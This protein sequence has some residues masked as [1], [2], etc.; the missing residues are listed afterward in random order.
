NT[1]THQP[2][3]SHLQ[4]NGAPHSGPDAVARLEAQVGGE[5]AP[6]HVK[7]DKEWMIELAAENNGRV[8]L[9]QHD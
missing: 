2:D 7:T 5:E 1:A 8:L 3:I 9:T 4:V 6:A